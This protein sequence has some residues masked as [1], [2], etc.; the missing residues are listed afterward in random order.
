[1]AEKAS[2]FNLTRHR[3]MSDNWVMSTETIIVTQGLQDLDSLCASAAAGQ[4]VDPVVARRVQERASK[5]RDELRKKGMTEIAV[6]LIR[7]VRDE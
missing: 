7:E 4:R 6:E 1:M 5:V 3:K 2:F